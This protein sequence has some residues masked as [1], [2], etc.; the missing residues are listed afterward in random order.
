MV[1]SRYQNG[2]INS[3]ERRE[4]YYCPT[5]I[6][7]FAHRRI[8]SH[9]KGVKKKASTEKESFHSSHHFQ[10]AKTIQSPINSQSHKKMMKVVPLFLALAGS[11]E[12]MTTTKQLF[13]T[14][15]NVQNIKDLKLEAEALHSL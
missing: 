3:R 8:P 4:N 13:I 11:P 6:D 5:A 14:N 12:C 2:H 9:A 15:A 1:P 7:T 10:F